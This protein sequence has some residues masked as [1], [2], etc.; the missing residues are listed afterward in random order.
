[1]KNVRRF[2]AF[3]VF[4]NCRFYYP[5][6]TVMFL[7]FGLSVAQFSILNAVWA[8]TIVLAEVPSGALADIVGRRR[9]LVFAAGSMLLEMAILCLAPGKRFPAVHLFCVQSRA[10]R[11]GRSRRQRCRRSHCL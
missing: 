1:M 2:I 5:V 8:A 9:L 4:F 6:F 7:D 10:Q 3:R 11:F